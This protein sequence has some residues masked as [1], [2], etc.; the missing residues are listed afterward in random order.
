MTDTQ[1]EIEGVVPQGSRFDITL[2]INVRNVENLNQ[3]LDVAATSVGRYGLDAFYILATNPDTGEQFVVHEDE[4]LPAD[5]ATKD[6]EKIANEQ[7]ADGS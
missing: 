6:L 5:E 4:I 2:L 7:T 3:A 1:P